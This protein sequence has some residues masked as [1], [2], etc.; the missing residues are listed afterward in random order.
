MQRGAREFST[1][2]ECISQSIRSRIGTW[3]EKQYGQRYDGT[4]V[5]STVQ[6]QEIAQGPSPRV[7][8]NHLPVIFEGSVVIRTIYKWFNSNNFH[9]QP[10]DL[11]IIQSEYPWDG[12]QSKQQG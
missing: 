1:V 6:H 11:W 8:E 9:L 3:S 5:N 10:L 12:V 7:P 2:C 4:F